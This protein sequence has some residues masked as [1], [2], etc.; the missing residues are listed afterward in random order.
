MAET[1]GQRAKRL[2][3]AIYTRKSSD[4]GLEQEFNSLHAQ[5][6]ACEAYILSQRH[7]GWHVLSAHYDDGGLS[8]GTMNRPALQQLLGDIAAGKVDAV[9][10][11]KIDRLTRSLFDFAKIVE[12]FDARGVSFVSV[13]QQFNTTTSMGRLTLNVLL[14]FAQFERE[15]TSERIRDKIAASKQKGMWMGGA[16]P[17]GYDA[18]NRKLRMNEKEAKTVRLLFDLYLK[19]GS[20]RKL[21][22]ECLRLGLRTKLRAMLDGRQSGGTAFSRGHLYRILSSPIY[23]GRIPHKGRSYEGEHEG[24]IDAETW[25]KVQAQLAMNAGRK[26]GR[27][28]SKHPSL[29]AGLLFTADGVPFTPSHAVNHGRRYRYYVERSLLTAGAELGKSDASQ[30][31][32]G[33]NGVQTKGWRLPAHQIEKLVLKQVASF[34]RDRGAV[35]DALGFKRQSP[36]LVSAVFARASTLAEGC[37]SGSVASSLEIV[38]ALVRRVTIAQERVTIEIDHAGLIERVTD[39]KATSQSKAKDRRPILIEVPVRF[40]RRGV[41]AKLVVLDQQQPTAGPDANLVKALTRAHQWFGRILRG[42]ATGIGDIAQAERLDRSYVA[43]VLCLAFLAPEV[44]KAMLEGRQPTELTAKR[45]ISSS[46]RMPLPWSDQPLT[47][48]QIG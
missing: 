18:I 27:T 32:G 48:C 25:D 6:E 13:T 34:L 10:V 2:R 14:S 36:D 35:L 26:R 31:N 38:T 16:V 45:L 42:E 39:Q 33:G 22:D 29:L 28:S 5:R 12:A 44:T 40:R 41:E 9:V 24:I 43:R 7:E 46:L 3:C 19:L 1:S 8:G 37:E 47:L 15:V 23:F 11:Y 30:P 4:E 17:L 20:V 21:Q